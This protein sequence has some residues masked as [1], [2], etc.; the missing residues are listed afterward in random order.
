MKHNALTIAQ[1]VRVTGLACYTAF[2]VVQNN[3]VVVEFR[4]R[5]G[6]VKPT[7]MGAV[8]HPAGFGLRRRRRKLG[9]C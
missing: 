7:A 8:R 2:V 6:K 9:H 1:I 4:L 5:R 3:I